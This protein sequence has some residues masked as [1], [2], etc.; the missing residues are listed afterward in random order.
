MNIDFAPLD[1]LP[2]NG[3]LVLLGAADGKLGKV[4]GNLDQ[5]TSGAI[6]RAIELAGDK[7]KRSSVDLVC[8]GGVEWDRIVVFALD[9]PAECSPHDLEVL[10]GKI[11]VK[12]NAL[13]VKTAATAI[14]ALAG[15][16]HSEL[17][18]ALALASGV[19][20]RNYRFD[21]YR[22][23]SEEE[24]ENQT[25]GMQAMTFHLADAGAASE[26]WAQTS[27]VIAGVEHGRDLVTEP[28]NV[29][30][31]AAFAEACKTMGDEVGLEVEV[32]DR[33]ALEKLGMR[34]LL[35]VA[36]GSEQDPFVVIMNWKGGAA[37]EQPVALVGKGVCFDTGGISLK[38]SGGMEEM[39]WDMGG[40]AAVFGAMKAIAGRKARANVVGVLGLV[41]NMPSGAAQRPGDVVAAMS[42]TTIEV[43][44]TDAE[45]RLV[46]AD[47]LHYTKERFQPKAMIDV[48]TLTGAVIIALGHEQ[49]GLFASDDGLA[50]QL[51]VAGEAVGE[52]VW[53]LPMDGGY[54]KHIKSEIA[55]IKNTGRAREAGATAGAVFLQHFVGDVPWAHLDI[56][57]VAWSKRDLPLAGK[58]A[59][60]FGARLLDRL[61]ADHFES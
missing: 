20:L 50:Q 53:R 36:Q 60:G 61:V 33:P 38:P 27:A 57:G 5:R 31:P 24:G 28:A 58:G 34:A 15:L 16:A 1:V 26:R 37:D 14:D 2:N 12:L 48:A 25:G 10:G 56:A 8:P 47:A 52:R 54:A 41:E 11:A 44:N 4:A 42:G 13:G 17:D 32:L 45:G 49:A 40:A 3:T 46:L 23:A 43:I 55:D 6:K 30:T 39:K 18:V 21:K 9:D 19:R 22:T 35:G 59:T 29:L 51:S 7:F